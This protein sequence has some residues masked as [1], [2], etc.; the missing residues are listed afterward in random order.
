MGRVECTNWPCNLLS[1][2]TQLYRRYSGILFFFEHDYNGDTIHYHVSHIFRLAVDVVY[3]EATLDTKQ[4]GIIGIP[5][6]DNH[7]IFVHRSHIHLIDLSIV[8]SLPQYFAH[9]IPLTS[10][11]FGRGM[12]AHL[13]P[14]GTCIADLFSVCATALN[15][16]AP[17]YHF[18]R[19]R[20][21]P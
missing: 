16:R 3:S 4:E 8:P 21:F 19:T 10:V 14:P 2:M 6:L 17:P 5:R 20:L 1:P 12:R 13:P 15:H 11:K 9:M 18:Y 7:L